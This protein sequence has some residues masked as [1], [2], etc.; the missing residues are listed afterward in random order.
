MANELTVTK[1]EIARYVHDAVEM[2]TALFT[3]D[4]AIEECENEIESR[5][6]NHIWKVERYEQTIDSNVRY[7]QEHSAI[8]DDNKNTREVIV[9]IKAPEEPVLKIDPPPEKPEI[10]EFR[11]NKGN[12]KNIFSALTLGLFLGAIASYP[13]GL[14]YETVGRYFVDS[15][16]AYFEIPMLIF[17]TLTTGII[18]TIIALIM[19]LHNDYKEQR[20]EYWQK[21][22]D[23]LERYDEELSRYSC[24]V[25]KAKDN[26]KDKLW[27]YH[28]RLDE[29]NKAYQKKLD[30]YR[31]KEKEL[32]T[33]KDELQNE[34]E[35]QSQTN[36][37]KAII[38]QQLAELR[39][40]RDELK[41]TLTC[42]YNYD[43]IPP[44]YRYL[45][46]V[47]VLDQIYRN[48]LAE[49]MKEAILLYETRVAR[50]EI[51]KGIDKIYKML[52]RLAVGMATIEQHLTS[53]NTNVKMM[54]Q[55][56]YSFSQQVATAQAAQLQATDDMIRLSREQINV[57]ARE[58][59]KNR[60]SIAWENALNRQE[61][62]Q[63]K[64]V[65]QETTEKL[66]RETQLSRY[67]TEQVAKG[68]NTLE[69]F[70]R[71]RTGWL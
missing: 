52:G 35:K 37:E 61:I 55:D 59:E 26:Y 8:L 44:D 49:T 5:Q 20:S 70:E 22:R 16:P 14:I 51:I 32:I 24:R 64:I 67:A 17:A 15:L 48:R 42:F 60:Q 33:A 47:I 30:E 58:N 13:I 23:L 27:A 19:E 43:I 38:D 39:S 9:N 36:Q 18:G 40:R 1:E 50:G 57:V 53:I 68:V 56:L 66:I 3:L 45:D 41:V 12:N 29:Y 10:G 2:E 11:Y 54:S 28:E 62:E 6:R 7:I 63:F 69:A 31:R 21:K 65:N 34:L 46:C 25:A 71:R 4:R